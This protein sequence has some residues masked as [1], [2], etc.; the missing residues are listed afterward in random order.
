VSSATNSPL[1]GRR[2]VV[3]RPRDQ[4]PALSLRLAAL[5]AEVIELPAIQVSREISKQALADVMLEFASYDWLVFTSANG[6]RF[7]FEEFFRLFDDIRSLGFIRI[8]C[9]GDSTSRQLTADLHLHVECQ[10]Q[11]ATAEALAGALIDTGSLDNAKVLVITGNLNRDALVRSLEEARAIVDCLQ[12][13]KTEKN[14]L[15]GTPAAADFRDRGADAILFTSSSAVESFADQAAGLAP[16]PEARRPLAGSIG[17][18]TSATM[19]KRG[20]AVDF[21]AKEPGIEELVDALARKIGRQ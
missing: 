7:F 13:Y 12:V 8:A 9:V 15:A 10:P 14:D 4:A 21:E 19:R 6:V 3:T 18:Q 5:G 11:K 1:S 20:M 2:V 17:P 16:S